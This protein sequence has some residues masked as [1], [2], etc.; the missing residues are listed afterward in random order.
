MVEV[1]VKQWGNSFGI[2]IP[3]EQ[4]RELGL[5][6]GDKIDVDIIKKERIDSFGIAKGAKPFVEEKEPHGDLF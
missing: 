2:V 5:E 6:K 3:M 1:E 4:I